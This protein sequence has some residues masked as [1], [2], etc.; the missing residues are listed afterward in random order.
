VHKSPLLIVAAVEGD[1]ETIA[2]CLDLGDYVDML[3]P[4]VSSWALM[5]S[6]KYLLN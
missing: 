3:D 1:V 5:I 4:N 2:A 6:Q